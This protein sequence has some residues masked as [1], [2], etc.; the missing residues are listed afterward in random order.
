MIDMDKAWQTVIAVILAVAG[1]LAR[2]LNLKDNTKLK[3]SKIVSELFIS[4]FAG[5]MVLMLARASGLSGDLV[6]VFAGVSG[7]IGPRVLDLI[8]NIVAKTAGVN[9]NETDDD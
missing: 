5:L 6:G 9:F 8:T 4:G 1:G 2:L 7:W 3:W